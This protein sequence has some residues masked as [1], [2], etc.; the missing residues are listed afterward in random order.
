MPFLRSL[1]GHAARRRCQGA[2]GRIQ[3]NQRRA[4]YSHRLGLGKNTVLDIVKRDGAG[5]RCKGSI[6]KLL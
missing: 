5:K 2:A 6:H 4:E 3:K 1:P